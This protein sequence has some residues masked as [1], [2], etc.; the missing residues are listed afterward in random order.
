M[1]CKMGRKRK[2]AERQIRN[3][4]NGKLYF[5]LSETENTVKVQDNDKN[6]YI[7]AKADVEIVE[8]EKKNAKD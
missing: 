4:Y 6:Y 5:A 1:G 3:I 7:M 8:K 2:Y